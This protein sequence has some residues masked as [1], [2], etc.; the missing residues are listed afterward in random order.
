MN[1][2]HGLVAAL[3]LGLALA[4]LP[5]RA[6]AASEI[7][8]LEEAVARHPGDADLVWALATRLAEADRKSD[9]VALLAVYVERWPERR[10]DSE[11]TLG[12]W[13]YDLGRDGE[14]LRHLERAVA[15]D[16]ASGAAHF[17]LA[18]AL[19]RL[20]RHD[21]ADAHFQRA[22]RAE[23]EL[24]AEA[25][26]MRALMCLESGD[27]AKGVALLRQTID[28][29]PTSELAQ[30]AR[31]ILGDAAT[32]P[33]P[34]IRVEA[35]S[36]VS[37]DSNV[38]LDS[39]TYVP[40]L[41]RD[42][43]DGRYDWGAAITADA[44]RGDA[45]A[46]SVGYRYDGSRHFELY[47]Y[48]TQSH[49]GFVSGR[50]RAAGPAM[51]RLDGL[52]RYATLGD[53]PYL[54]NATLRPNL[55]VTL[56]P[57]AGV[58]HLFAEGQWLEYEDAPLVPSLE[59]D[60]WSYGA[61]LEHA[62]SLPHWRGAWALLGVDFARLDTDGRVDALGFDSAYDHDRWRGML[63]LHLP[64]WWELRSDVLAAFGTERYPNKNLI[65][66]LSDSL[67][68]GGFDPATAS[69][70]CDLVSD[71][72]IRLTRPITRFADAELSYRFFDRSSNV[73]LYTYDRSVVSF[74]VRVHPF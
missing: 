7:E 42:R 41:S 8:R 53:D 46:V 28:L 29:D 62:V 50:W 21:E 12:R 18:L 73:D 49:L 52:F 64:L 74:S 1:V 25:L 3:T 47:E 70:R 57:R 34:R 61:G 11:L 37:Y 17:H 9:A 6:E 23:S 2:A 15:R 19:K 35:F 13:L 4:P 10:S 40:G 56:G 72:M 39:G 59:R 27:E 24:R 55:Y 54:S 51:L 33:P 32:P 65:D 38:V 66:F 45:G 48:D 67:G 16:G 68:G 43:D 14:A 71:L 36:G 22:E 69:R 30:S 58:L 63:R 20:G 31:L 26:I 60:G 5:A 44:L